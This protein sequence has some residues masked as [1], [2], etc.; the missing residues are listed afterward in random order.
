MND[1]DV[2]RLI[3][4]KIENISAEIKEKEKALNHLSAK[5]TEAKDKLVAEIEEL[6]RKKDKLEGNRS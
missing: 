5:H 1:F 2:S 4:T 3:K 6:K